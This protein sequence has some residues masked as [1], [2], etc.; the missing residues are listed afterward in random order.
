MWK[1][2]TLE[3]GSELDPG[4]LEQMPDYITFNITYEAA[5]SPE[6]LRAIIEVLRATVLDNWTKYGDPLSWPPPDDSCIGV[7]SLLERAAVTQNR[8]G[9][10]D[11]SN[12]ASDCLFIPFSPLA[13]YVGWLFIHRVQG[14][15]SIS[16]SVCDGV[17]TVSDYSRMQQRQTLDPSFKDPRDPPDEPENPED[18]AWWTRLD[19]KTWPRYRDC[20]EL[21]ALNA[22]CLRTLLLRL[23]EAMP[24]RSVYVNEMFEQT[25]A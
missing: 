22:E 7:E 20:D 12:F 14:R 5:Y 11:K 8:P 1:E 19:S 9:G 18:P 3:M 23:S 21:W 2:F 4:A 24:T 16:F 25:V 15:L 17:T 10:E 6:S 13:M